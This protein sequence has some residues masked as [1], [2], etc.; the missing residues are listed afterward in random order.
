MRSRGARAFTLVELLVVIAVIAVLVGILLP[1][2]GAARNRGRL[3]ISLANVRSLNQGADMYRGDFRGYYPILPLYERGTSAG[4]TSGR[5]EWWCSWAF[6]GKNN[7]AWWAGRMFDVESADR[8]LNPYLMPDPLPAPPPPAMMT[9]TDPSRQLQIPA[10]KDPSDIVSYQRNDGNAFRT[11]PVAFPLSSY[12]DVGTSYHVNFKWWGQL[13]TSFTALDRLRLGADRF[14]IG[15]SF[16]PARMVW[17]NDQYADVAVNNRSSSFQLENGYREVNKAVLGFLDGRAD[18]QP[19][20]PGQRPESFT[21][22]RHT[23]VF[24]DL[25][26]PPRQ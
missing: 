9:A 7:N 19:V 15:D 3:V 16:Q 24:E 1:A 8:P 18:Y 21:N 11:N 12:D 10:F 26:M 22:A 6:G 13:P 20:I 17:I 23:F 4:A 25:R 5:F 14:R 2:L